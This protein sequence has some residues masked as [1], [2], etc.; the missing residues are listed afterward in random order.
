MGHVRRMNDYE[1]T[2]A[3]LIA[4]AIGWVF[5]FCCRRAYANFFR[6]DLTQANLIWG[7]VFCCPPIGIIMAY[8]GEE[9][10]HFLGGFF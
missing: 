7:I 6:S 1:I 2:R 3:A 10:E 8:G 4:L 5:V 9:L